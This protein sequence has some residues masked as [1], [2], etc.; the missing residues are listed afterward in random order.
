MFAIHNLQLTILV[1]L[2]CERALK[3]NAIKRSAARLHNAVGALRT[4][5]GPFGDIKLPYLCTS[6]V[7]SLIKG[8][9]N[10][11]RLEF[12]TKRECNAKPLEC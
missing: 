9:G 10:F 5:Y 3:S 7:M 4:G 6:N 2:L 11:S 8:L 1:F 12:P